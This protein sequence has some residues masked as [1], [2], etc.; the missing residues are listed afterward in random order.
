MKL[1]PYLGNV[2]IGDYV[3]EEPCMLFPFNDDV[4]GRK[5]LRPSA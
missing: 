4:E 3:L 2:A 1:L 5:I